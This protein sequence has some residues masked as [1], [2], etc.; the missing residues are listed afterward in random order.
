MRLEDCAMALASGNAESVKLQM[1]RAVA[2]RLVGNS[3]IIRFQS[4]YWR[5]LY[6]L[7]WPADIGLRSLRTT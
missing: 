4:S 7:A 3:D 6:G 5:D 2:G 1:T